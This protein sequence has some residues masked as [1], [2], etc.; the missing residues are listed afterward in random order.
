[1]KRSAPN[2]MHVQTKGPI[3]RGEAGTMPGSCHENECMKSFDKYSMPR[4]CLSR[5]SFLGV[6]FTQNAYAESSAFAVKESLST[7]N[8]NVQQLPEVCGQGR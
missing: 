3:W 7:C 1:M 2:W 6:T 8:I 4:I 5:A